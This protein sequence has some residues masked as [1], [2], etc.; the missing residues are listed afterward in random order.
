MLASVDA[1]MRARLFIQAYA[2]VPRLICILSSSLSHLLLLLFLLCNFSSPHAH[3]KYKN[4]S[5]ISFFFLVSYCDAAMYRSFR[6]DLFPSSRSTWNCAAIAAAAA[7]AVVLLVQNVEHST[8]QYI[9]I[10]I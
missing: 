3:I 5:S 10:N 7:A 4:I 9:S 8:L 2:L 6:S 1:T